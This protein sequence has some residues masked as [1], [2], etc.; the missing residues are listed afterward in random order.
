MTE[1]KSCPFCGGEA[2]YDP[3]HTEQGDYVDEV[4][5]ENIGCR[6]LPKSTCVSKETAITAWNT[7]ADNWQPIDEGGCIWSGIR[8]GLMYDREKIESAFS[9]PKYELESAALDSVARSMT[10][11]VE[12]CLKTARN[13]QPP[14]PPKEK[15]NE[16][17]DD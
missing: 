13:R 1:L 3:P 16:T 14:E 7:R 6:V 11:R 12:G 15:T 8:S 9:Q 17:L 5:C 4:G 10:A 2:V